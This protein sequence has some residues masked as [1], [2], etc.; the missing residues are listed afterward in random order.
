MSKI[1]LVFVGLLSLVTAAYI[2]I[3]TQ[4]WYEAVPGVKSTGPLNMH[5]ARDVALAYLASGAALIWAGARR[6]G[7]A[8][9]CGSAWLVLH[10]L[11]HIWIWIHRGAPFDT[12]ALT[13]LSGIQLPAF[14]ALVAAL[15]LSNEE[16]RL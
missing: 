10:A 14:A 1:V 3:A 8:A 7:S 2:W 13:N 4:H 15:R 9:I 11:F 6:D 5:F 12:V 16:A